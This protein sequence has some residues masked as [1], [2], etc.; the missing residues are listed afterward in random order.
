MNI[1]AI[2]TKLSFTE[3][4]YH[5]YNSL[6]FN[7]ERSVRN[8]YNKSVTKEMVEYVLRFITSYDKDMSHQDKINTA[9]Q[10]ICS[11][12]FH[13]PIKLTYKRSIAYKTIVDLIDDEMELDFIRVINKD[14]IDALAKI[15]NVHIKSFENNPL[16]YIANFLH[17]NRK[18]VYSD[19]ELYDKYKYINLL[20]TTYALAYSSSKLKTKPKYVEFYRQ[21]IKYEYYDKFLI[22]NNY[23]HWGDGLFEI[24]VHTINCYTDLKLSYIDLKKNDM[25]LITFILDINKLNNKQINYC[26]SKLYASIK[27]KSIHLMEFRI[28]D[29]V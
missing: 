10:A 22:E 4:L 24:L 11:D 29:V 19:E 12:I 9:I 2:Q 7:I 5:K 14:T 23:D 28:C 26:I 25:N 1:F 16:K 13:N 6:I 21:F 3:E 27:F 15:S 20:M 8:E 18:E 17:K